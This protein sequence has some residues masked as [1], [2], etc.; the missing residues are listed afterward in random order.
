SQANRL[1]HYL[2][3]LGVQPGARVAIRLERSIDLVLA[4]LAILKCGAAYAPLDRNAPVERQSLI[5]EDSEASLALSVK[6]L[7]AAEIICA[8]QVEIDDLRLWEQ[9]SSNP[10]IALESEMAAYVI[11]TSGSTGQPKG[12]VIP[13]RAIVRLAFNRYASFGAGDRVAFTSNP[14][15]DASTMEVWATLLNGGRV[16]VIPESVLLEA[17]KIEELL[18][19]EEVNILHLVAGLL[20]VHAE[21]LAPIF[22]RLKY[23][24]TGG[25]VVD[26]HAVARI[27]SQSPPEHLV[28]CYGPSESTTFATT[29]EVKEVAEGA[30]N[31]PIGRPI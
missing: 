14:A 27:L 13:H 31:L 29:D 16:V 3:A 21:P 5:V 12:V 25:D 2:R 9:A 20:S 26:T 22:R 11:Y 1:A 24:L 23:L 17:K 6:D 18:G 10:E 8:K 7:G 4:E 19:R 30:K 15:F 28:H